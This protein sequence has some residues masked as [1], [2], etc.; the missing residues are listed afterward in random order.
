M[1]FG[2]Q[3]NSLEV[4]K[5]LLGETG[6]NEEK[7]NISNVN[8]TCSGI[9]SDKTPKTQVDARDAEAM[10]SRAA[11][12]PSL[13]E[14]SIEEGEARQAVCCLIVKGVFILGFLVAASVVTGIVNEN[15]EI[16]DRA[17]IGISVTAFAAAVISSICLL[18]KCGTTQQCEH[19]SYYNKVKSHDVESAHSIE[20]RG[21]ESVLS[22]YDINKE[23]DGGILSSSMMEAVEDNK[24][25]SEEEPQDDLQ[26]DSSDNQTE[27]SQSRPQP[28]KIVTTKAEIHG[29]RQETTV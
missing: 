22:A 5:P 7:D 3:R 24:P 2:L 15:P 29:L 16:T 25:H 1:D 13:Q 6:G 20:D 26:A 27:L 4:D 21:K 28:A 9:D 12:L 17:K 10:G 19:A 18:C 14:S 23:A 11:S 8:A